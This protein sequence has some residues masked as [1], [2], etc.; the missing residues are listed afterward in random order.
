MKEAIYVV[1]LNRFAELPADRRN[2]DWCGPKRYRDLTSVVVLDLV[3][4]ARRTKLSRTRTSAMG[5]ASADVRRA[6]EARMDASIMKS[7]GSALVGRMNAGLV[8][9]IR[10]NPT[11]MPHVRATL[12]TA[13]G[14]SLT[15]VDGDI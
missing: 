4:D 6:S 1:R 8:D 12:Y 3:V 7:L 11:A 15:K 5:V 9:R 14:G 13:H 2:L 10:C